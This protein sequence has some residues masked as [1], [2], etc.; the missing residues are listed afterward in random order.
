M[1]KIEERMHG[2]LTE[3]LNLIRGMGGGV[4]FEEFPGA[5][6]GD[7]D[8]PAAGSVTQRGLIDEANKLAEAL[9]RLRGREHGTCE[10]YGN[11]I[12]PT[13]VQSGIEFTG[14]GRTI[15]CET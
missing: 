6:E 8:A 14:K 13:G 4:V 3:L 2:E 10:E 11:P 5:F 12:T 1:T 15:S 7:I 9:E